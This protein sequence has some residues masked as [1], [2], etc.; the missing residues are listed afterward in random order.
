MK[1]R[2]H[3]CL[4]PI[5]VLS[6][7][8]TAL[9]NFCGFRALTYKHVNSETIKHSYMNLKYIFLLPTLFLT[10]LNLNA[11]EKEYPDGHGKTVKLPQG[12]ISFADEVVSYK[13]GNPAP[14]PENSK[15]KDAVGIPDFNGEKISGFVSL[16]T[17]GELVLQFTDNALINIDGPDL[18]VFEMGKY[19]EETFLYVSKDNKKWIN[20]GKISGGNALVD[21]GDS[22]KPGEIFRYIKLIDAKTSKA[23]DKM[24]PGADI[25]AVAA[26]GSAKQISL[27]ATTLF[28]VNKSELK[29]EAKKDLDKIADE[30]NLNPQYYLVVDGHCDSTGNKANNEKLSKDRANSVKTY[31]LSRLK[32]KTT[33]INA[34]GYSDQY[35]IAPNST[36]QGREKNRRVE[37]YLVPEAKKK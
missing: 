30:V 17:G 24:W 20:V 29:P 1:C 33:K 13:A 35:P 7:L 37:V 23:N 6:L 11:Q 10:T 36:P 9:R 22:T 15:P 34:N 32:N 28:N 14:I 8:N 18:Y 27:N 3:N 25:D 12:D 21:I 26:L 16:G 4:W 5:F 2:G 19:V 31:L